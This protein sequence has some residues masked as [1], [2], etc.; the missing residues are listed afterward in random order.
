M[1]WVS[2]YFLGDFQQKSVKLV[3]LCDVGKFRFSLEF[4]KEFYMPLYF[5]GD[6]QVSPSSREKGFALEYLWG[7]RGRSLHAVFLEAIFTFLYPAEKRL[8]PWVSLSVW[9]K[10]LACRCI[11]LGDFQVSP[12][13]SKKRFVPALI[14]STANKAG[15]GYCKSRYRISQRVPIVRAC[16][17]YGPSFIQLSF[18]QLKN[19]EYYLKFISRNRLF[20]C[21]LFLVCPLV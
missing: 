12:S 15:I 16:D 5:L 18:I 8:R 6:F 19:I 17:L 11:F 13:S 10:N 3:E 7:F 21:A 20:G 2:L 14:T 1:L 9:R 4:E